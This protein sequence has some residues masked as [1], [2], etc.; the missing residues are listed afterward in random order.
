MT[1]VVTY[2]LPQFASLYNELD[3]PLPTPT[4]ILLAIALPLRSYFIVFGG[5]FCG[6]LPSRFSSGRDRIAERWRSTA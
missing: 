4:R 1:Y 3:V 2:A 6:W 5:I